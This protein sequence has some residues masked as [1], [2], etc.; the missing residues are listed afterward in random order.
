MRREN[1]SLY[2]K[3]EKVSYELEENEKEICEIE[4]KH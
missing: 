3:I 4:M 2:L 1:F